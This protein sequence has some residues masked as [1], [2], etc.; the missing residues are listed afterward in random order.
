[1]LDETIF[2]ADELD[3]VKSKISSREIKKNVY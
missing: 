3:D 1:V 2:F